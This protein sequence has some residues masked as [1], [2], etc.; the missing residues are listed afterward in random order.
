[1]KR[2]AIFASGEGS[3][4]EAIVKYFRCKENTKIEFVLSNRNLAGVHNRMECLGI[5]TFTYSKDEWQNPK[6]I[7]NKLKER[8][9]DLIVLAGFLAI[10]S[11]EIIDEYQGR[12]INIH[13]SLLPKHGG[14]GMW[15]MNV[16]RSVLES[17][18][19]ESGITIHYVDKKI[20]GGNIIAQYK[21][22]VKEDDSAEILANRV[23]QLEYFYYPRVIEEILSKY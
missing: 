16:H 6:E 19:R 21:C 2:I 20:D 18:D 5:P 10:I 9:I 17:K 3:N 14:H 11:H 15:G 12:I 1:M 8:S 13:P 7:I 22:D 23:H 4:A